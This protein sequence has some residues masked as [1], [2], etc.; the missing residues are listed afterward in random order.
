MKIETLGADVLNK[1]EDF[2]G[3][4]KVV[5]VRD[6]GA[7]LNGFIAVHNANLG[8]ALGGCRMVKYA[9]EAVNR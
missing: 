6:E 4:H 2:D 3:H 7:G 9:G 8:P 1:F 5:H